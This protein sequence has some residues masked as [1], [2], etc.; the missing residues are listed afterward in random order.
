MSDGKEPPC[1]PDF[2][3]F[4]PT[5]A[6]PPRPPL[7]ISGLSTSSEIKLG[8]N[9]GDGNFTIRATGITP[10]SEG[11]GN[12]GVVLATDDVADETYFFDDTPLV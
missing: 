6:P 12:T 8:L 7:R 5:S 10:G 3:R 9:H 4:E 11:T 2:L 1:A